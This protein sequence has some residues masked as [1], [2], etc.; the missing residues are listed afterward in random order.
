MECRRR[1]S[2]GLSLKDS[3]WKGIVSDG[4]HG[5]LMSSRFRALAKVKEPEFKLLAVGSFA[6]RRFLPEISQR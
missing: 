5:R 4:W 1:R 3:R 2:S 6:E